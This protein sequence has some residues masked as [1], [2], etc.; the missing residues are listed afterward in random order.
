MREMEK[1]EITIRAGSKSD[2]KRRGKG[3]KAEWKLSRQLRRF[4]K[5]LRGKSAIRGDQYSPRQSH[6]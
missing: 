4:S 5:A 6:L 1:T 3:R 2:P